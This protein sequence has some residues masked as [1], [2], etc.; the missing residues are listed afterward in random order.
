MLTLMELHNKFLEITQSP[1]FMEH[2]T[3]ISSR[4]WNAIKCGP[5]IMMSWYDGVD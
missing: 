5:Q 1:T 4:P 3:I 2:L